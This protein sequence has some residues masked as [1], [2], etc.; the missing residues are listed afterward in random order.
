VL[1]DLAEDLLL[2]RHVFEHGLDHEIGI[3]H[4]FGHVGDRPHPL[5]RRLVVAEIAQVGRDPLLSPY[6]GSACA[7]P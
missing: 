1:L 5:D 3:A 7:N 4:A 6:R 2:Q